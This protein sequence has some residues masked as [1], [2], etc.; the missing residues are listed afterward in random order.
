VAIQS[1]MEEAARGARLMV[2][3]QNS[4]WQW[5]FCSTEKTAKAGFH[6]LRFHVEEMKIG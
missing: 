4:V 1:P 5:R 2:H 6:C 3:G